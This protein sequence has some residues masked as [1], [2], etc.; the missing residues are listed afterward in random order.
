MRLVHAADIHLDSPL[1]GLTR[2]GDDDLADTLRQATRRA[3]ENLVAYTVDCKADAM[4]L[5]GDVYDGNWRDYATGRFFVEQMGRLH[6]ENIPVVMIAGNHDA[7]SEITR[8]L[9]RPPN[10]TMLRTDEPDVKRFPHLGLAVH[11]QGF[12]TRAVLDNLVRDYRPPE[13]GMVNVGLLHT[14]LEGAEGHDTYAPCTFDDLLRVGYDYFALGHVH[15]HRVFRD[16]GGHP[17]AAFS[18]NLQGRHPRETGPKGALVVD[19]EPGQPVQL[20]HVPMDVA[21]WSTPDLD[22]TGCDDLDAV[23][24]FVEARLRDE[25]TQAGQRPVIARVDLHGTAKAAAALA[26]SEKLREEMEA[27]A[28]RSGVALER[29]RAR[30]SSPGQPEAVDPELVAAIAAGV[31]ELA[32]DAGSLSIMVKPLE[33]EFGRVLRGAHLLDLKN[34]DTLADLARRAGEELAARLAGEGR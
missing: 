24:E 5:A 8:S 26:D 28:T 3:L 30:V 33:A 10:V 7:E 32:A 12:A 14:A 25:R 29:V 21:R 31:T 1:R 17:K 16:D 34:P 9:R 22:V 13:P 2:L 11:G 4:L 18:G 6:D 27:L 19:V 20:S 15:A 23:L